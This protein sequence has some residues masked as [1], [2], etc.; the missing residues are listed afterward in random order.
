MGPWL[1]TPFAA[2]AIA[3]AVGPEDGKALADAVERG[4]GSVPWGAV[5]VHHSGDAA[6][7]AAS[8]DRYQRESLGDPDGID[9]HFVI[10]NGLGLPDGAVEVTARWTRGSITSHLFRESGLPPAVSI[11]LVG[12]LENA[13]P[14]A[15]QRA[16]LSRLIA[17]LAGRFRL[18]I[19]A[20]LLH[21][22]VEGRGTT[23]PG[24]KL[25]KWKMLEEAGL[26]PERGRSVLVER[27][28]SAVKLLLGE[29]VVQRWERLPDRPH[30]RLPLGSFPI[31]RRDEGGA[32]GRTLVIAWP[33]PDEIH[34]A[35]DAG[36]LT[37]NDA[38]RLLAATKTGS[39]PPDDTPLGGEIGIHAGGTS[40]AAEESACAELEERD[41][42]AL[43]DA[44]PLGT[45]VRIVE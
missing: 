6:G 21:R 20:V 38:R 37:P 30:R 14:T 42:D 15:A 24:R 35:R 3:V 22:E 40:S 7:S 43:F 25:S 17:S 9:H 41:A 26:L 32:F 36:T 39:C 11:C 1:A 8:I 31:C 44:V 4:G 45:V 28:G 33:G 16:A 18:P 19:D 34:A 12:D 13:S 10:G 5:V 23:C 29:A 2:A 27:G